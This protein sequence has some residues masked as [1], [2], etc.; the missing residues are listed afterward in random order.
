MQEQEQGEKLKFLNV[1]DSIEGELSISDSNTP[2]TQVAKRV[3]QAKML[4]R[5]ST[6][7]GLNTVSDTVISA[8]R[9]KENEMQMKLDNEKNYSANTVLV[10][11]TGGMLFR[12]EGETFEEFYGRFERYVLSDTNLV[13]PAATYFYQQQ[14][15]L[16]RDWL[17][18]PISQKVNSRVDS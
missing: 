5:S 8:F 3:L 17:A 11:Y 10:F 7:L 18:S 15:T 12:E 9:Q 2:N 13:D 4:R 1:K 16:N 14:R 6:L